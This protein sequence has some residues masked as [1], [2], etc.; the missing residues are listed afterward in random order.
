MDEGI[1]CKVECDTWLTVSRGVFPF[2]LSGNHGNCEAHN[3]LPQA[4]TYKVQQAGH[5]SHLPTHSKNHP[6]IQVPLPVSFL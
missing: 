5:P 4:G 2:V 6:A 1:G 3:D